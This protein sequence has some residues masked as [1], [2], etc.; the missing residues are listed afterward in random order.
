MKIRQLLPLLMLVSLTAVAED[1]PEVL[2]PPKGAQVALVV[3]EDLQC[4][5]C[6]RAAPLVAQAGQTYKIPVVRHDFPLPMHNW[7][8]EAAVLAR[9]FDT[10]SKILGNAFRDSVFE[11]QLE[12]TPD[13][14]HGFAEKF[15]AEHKV[16]LPFVVDPAGRLAA[17]VLADRELGKSI[18]L[19][20]T[21]TIFVVSN[22]R[23]GKPFVEVVDRS[24]LYALIDSMKRE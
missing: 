2:R 19:Q 6:R 24:Q 13:N 18:N 15:A 7:S 10:H 14:L 9:Y 3:F 11:H 8:F 22:K 21:P 1:V 5:D 20:H 17:L 4:P 12:I 23:A 16:D